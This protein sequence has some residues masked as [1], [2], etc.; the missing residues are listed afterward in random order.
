MQTLASTRRDGTWI[1]HMRGTQSIIAS[2]DKSSNEGNGIVASL[3]LHL[4]SFTQ[5]RRSFRSVAGG[6]QRM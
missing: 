6:C 4:V 2:R 5:L 1:T 3:C